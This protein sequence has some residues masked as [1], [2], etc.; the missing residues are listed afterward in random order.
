MN[1]I[2]WTKQQTREFL[3]NYHFINNKSNPSIKDVFNRIQTIQYDPLNVVGTNSELVLQSRI[4]TFKKQDLYNA[5]YKERYLIDNWDK[6]M[7]IIKTEDFSKLS[8]IREHRAKSEIAAYKDHLQIESLDF[9]D[10]V[11]NIIRTNGPKYSSEIKIGEAKK[12][13]LGKTKPSSAA[14]DY[15]FHQGIIG[16]R[17]RRNTQKQY[18]LIENLVPNLVSHTYESEEEF[19]LYYLLRR[20]KSMGLIWNK[21][22]VHFSGLHINKK[23]LRSKYL[24]IL[25]T[26]KLIKSIQVED[27]KELF[28]IPSESLKYEITLL[29]RISFIAPLD[30]LIWDRSL[31]KELFNFEYTWEVYTPVVK[32][33]Y[34]YYVLPIL[35]GSDFIGRIEFEKQRN[36]ETLVVKQIWLEASVKTNK[37]LDKQIEQALKQFSKYLGAIKD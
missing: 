21:S 33:K 5:L 32:R 8:L 16:I 7:G 22:G 2:F 14:L 1:T 26:K 19:I 13:R 36:Q 17:E 30:N 3:I 10:D 35:K 24:K 20:I 12:H 15:L 23:S 37:S 18:D 6:Q 31:I 4:K 34:G 9:V 28:Y 25:E 27:I 29:D 11:L